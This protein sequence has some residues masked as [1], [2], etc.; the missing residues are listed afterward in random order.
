MSL[1]S[2]LWP[3]SRLRKLATVLVVLVGLYALAGFV[4]LPRLLP[5]QITEAIR[6][7][8][9]R[10]ATIGAMRINPFLM[11][12]GVDAF[13]LADTDGTAMIEA[14]ELFV[15][16]DVL[17]SAAQRAIVFDEVRLAGIRIN[18]VVDAAGRNNLAALGESAA[19]EPAAEPTPA[20]DADEATALPPVTITRLDLDDVRASFRDLAAAEPFEFELG[21]LT[22]HLTDLSTRRDSESPYSIAATAPSGEELE[23]TGS[24]TIDPLRSSGT[25]ALDNLS[26]TRLWRYVR[27]KL[28][29]GLEVADADVAASYELA[30]EGDDFRFSLADGSVRVRDIDVRERGRDDSVLALGSLDIDGIGLDLAAAKVTVDRVGLAGGGLTVVLDEAGE[31]NLARLAPATAAP[32]GA[33]DPAAAAA[34]GGDAA[35]AAPAATD[36][37]AGAWTVA[38]GEIGLAD[39]AVDV[40]DRSA[41]PAFALRL[42]PVD[43]TV[44]GFGTAP[45][46]TFQVATAI[47]VADSGRLTTALESRLEPL[48]VS[49]TVEVAGLGLPT[50]AGYVSRF[51][52]VTLPSG[53]VAAAGTVALAGD[54]AGA[55]TVRYDGSLEVADLAV[56]LADGDAELVRWQR[57][58]LKDVALD[59]GRNALVVGAVELSDPF[60]QVEIDETGAMT[61]DRVRIVGAD[62]EAAAEVAA[63]ENDDGQAGM[64]V[65]V[66]QIRIDGGTVQFVDRS[67]QPPFRTSLDD[68]RLSLGGFAL[69]DLGGIDLDLQAKVDDDAPLVIKGTLSPPGYREPADVQIALTGYDL[70]AVT[71]YV[72]RYVGYE[73]DKGKLSLKLGYKLD[74]NALVGSNDIVAQRFTLGDRIESPDATTLPV[75]MALAVLRDSQGRIALDV[76]VR[77]KVDDPQFSIRNTILGTLGNVLQK[78]ITSPFSMLGSVA[79]IGGD[80]LSHIDFAPGSDAL[81]ESETKKIDGLAEALGKRPGLQLEIRGTADA[82][83]D[84]PALADALLAARLKSLWLAGQGLDEATLGDRPVEIDPATRRQLLFDLYAETFGRAIAAPSDETVEERAE[85]AAAAVRQK[86]TAGPDDLARLGRER[87]KVIRDAL[88]ERGVPRQQL[89]RVK[90]K[91]VDKGRTPVRVPLTLSATG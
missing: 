57:L 3:A 5:A 58:G 81:T 86:L 6:T 76:P 63:G 64:N 73:I 23:W 68:L 79:G 33:T 2:L 70:T 27:G 28:P 42:A 1:R 67:V 29:I 62:G 61:I 31:L 9:A 72:G 16:L 84:A 41:E 60:A 50:F 77:G 18:A 12:V 51:A 65:R 39:F 83:A 85:R 56:R 8:V 36:D 30:M 47:G 14:G 45:G 21:P 82:V 17:S 10:E 66:E 22:L 74:R 32:A 49:G 15:D 54:D 75:K 44:T 7:A 90:A 69:D 88:A 37:D 24:L 89:F 35:A 80:K 71:P 55:T 53:T 26:L 13:S 4:V 34:G 48:S 11:S 43:V 40:T 38:V 20:V 59:T 78:A 91:V 52:R 46:T 87:S 25:V 19:A